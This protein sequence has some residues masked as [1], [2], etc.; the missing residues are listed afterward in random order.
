MVAW[1]PTRAP[2]RRIIGACRLMCPQERVHDASAA[3][4]RRADAA[5]LETALVSVWL[6]LHE[7]CSMQRSLWEGGLVHITNLA[8]GYE[9]GHCQVVH[10][11]SDR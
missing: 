9:P 3:D 5:M 7:Q 1:N 11:H 10:S 4:A 8:L 6:A 2:G